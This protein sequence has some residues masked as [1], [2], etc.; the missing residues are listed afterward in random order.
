MPGRRVLLLEGLRGVEE[1]GSIPSRSRSRSGEGRGRKR[2]EKRE[3]EG[4][5][6]KERKGEIMRCDVREGIGGVV[7]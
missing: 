6:G 3:W 4:S 1:R 5:G 2:G 7:I